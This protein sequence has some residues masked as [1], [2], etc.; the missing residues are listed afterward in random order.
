MLQLHLWHDFY[1]IVFKIKHKLYI[2][3]GS[4]PPVK[5][6]G[7]MPGKHQSQVIH[8]PN[9]RS[10]H[11]SSRVLIGSGHSSGDHLT[12]YLLTPVAA[13]G[14]YP[15]LN[16][17]TVTMSWTY[18]SIGVLPTPPVKAHMGDIRLWEISGF[19]SSE[20]RNNSLLGCDVAWSR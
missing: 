11:L 19:H 1:N 8:R 18:M 20:C 12:C 15:P 16:P 13:N 4:A 3:S 7:C 10:A 14:K 17:V 6:S 5:N 2:A 9:N